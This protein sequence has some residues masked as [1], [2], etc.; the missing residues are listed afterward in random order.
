LFHQI[1]QSKVIFQVFNIIVVVFFF[2]GYFS[3]NFHLSKRY[4]TCV[5]S[6]SMLKFSK[7]QP[8]QIFFSIFCL[9]SFFQSIET[10]K[11]IICNCRLFFQAVLGSNNLR[12]Q[13]YNDDIMTIRTTTFFSCH[14]F[15]NMQFFVAFGAKENEFLFFR[16]NGLFGN[17]I[18]LKNT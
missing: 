12:R 8:R 13:L 3:H 14:A 10:K 1:N 6:K 11:R 5:W 4:V 15:K 7:L 18:F 9:T 16:I 17:A 2:G